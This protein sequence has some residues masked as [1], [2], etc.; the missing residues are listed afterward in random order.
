M[1]LWCDR[2]P[3]PLTLGPKRIPSQARAL[4][5]YA[6]AVIEQRIELGEKIRRRV[7]PW[8]CAVTD[9]AL[10]LGLLQDDGRG[11][12]AEHRHGSPPAGAERAPTRR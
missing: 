2:R 1:P 7:P 4:V 12:A 10:P 6:L 5:T 11:A 9:A 8:R 3:E